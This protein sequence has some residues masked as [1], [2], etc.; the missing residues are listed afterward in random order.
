MSQRMG[1]VM[2]AALIVVLAFSFLIG[3]MLSVP[4]QEHLPPRVPTKWDK[5]I[6]ELDAEALDRAYVENSIRLFS[7][8]MKDEHDQPHRMS[9]GLAR[10]RRAYADARDRLELRK[11]D[12][13]QGK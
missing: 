1:Y 5:H 9:V 10:S 2:F 7:V 8:W 4:G 3:F 11:R 12:V 6:L 13:E